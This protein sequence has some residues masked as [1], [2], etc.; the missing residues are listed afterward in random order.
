[1]ITTRYEYKRLGFSTAH[2]QIVEDGQS[3]KVEDGLDAVF[4]QRVAQLGRE[5]WE[6]AAGFGEV[7]VFKRIVAAD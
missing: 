7:L 3:R 5:G 2:R 1:M 6:L 4:W